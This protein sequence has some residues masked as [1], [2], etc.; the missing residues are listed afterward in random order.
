MKNIIAMAAETTAMQTNT[1]TSRDAI[2]H[3]ASGGGATAGIDGPFAAAGVTAGAMPPDGFE[4][5][6]FVIVFQAV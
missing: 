4:L 6:C 1:R 2:S 5:S 3:R